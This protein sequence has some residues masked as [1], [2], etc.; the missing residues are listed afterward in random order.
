VDPASEEERDE[1]PGE[2]V[3]EQRE[4]IAEECLTL[5]SDFLPSPCLSNSKMTSIDIMESREIKGV[6]DI[7]L[8]CMEKLLSL[9]K[10]YLGNS[11]T[12]FRERSYQLIIRSSSCLHKFVTEVFRYCQLSSSEKHCG[13]SSD[14]D[15]GFW[16]SFQKFIKSSIQS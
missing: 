7:R 2:E 14:I 13:I 4:K 12:S 15:Y 11:V 16:M 10:T 6:T 3:E 9:L 5:A 8:Q 1:E